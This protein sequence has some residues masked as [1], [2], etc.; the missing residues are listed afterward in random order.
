MVGFNNTSKP[1]FEPATPQPCV[2]RGLVNAS[3]APPFPSGSYDRSLCVINVKEGRVMR[4]IEGV[5]EDPVQVDLCCADT[6]IVTVVDDA[7]AAYT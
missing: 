1:G 5:G 7:I 6:V 3:V 4:K 2:H